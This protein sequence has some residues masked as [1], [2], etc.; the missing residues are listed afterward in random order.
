MGISQRQLSL[1]VINH[2]MKVA[3]AMRLTIGLQGKV[4]EVYARINRQS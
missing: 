2:Y 4:D 3:R 1:D